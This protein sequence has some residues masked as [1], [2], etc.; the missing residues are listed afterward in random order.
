MMPA[1]RIRVAGI[2]VKDSRILLVRHEKNGNSYW[3]LPGGGMEFGETAEEALVREF[4]EE[5]G[6]DISVGKL[7]LV[8]DSIPPNR[9]RQVLNLY[10]LVSASRFDIKVTTDGVLKDAS[11]YPLDDFKDMIVN[12]DVKTEILSGLSSNWPE[13]CQ[14]LGNRWKD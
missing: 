6:L 5:V 2:L 14:Y 10:F 8:Q 12:P 1:I 4:K 7:I 11:F 3:L 9:H 13:G